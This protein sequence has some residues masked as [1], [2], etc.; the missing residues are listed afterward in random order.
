M[1][2][3]IGLLLLAIYLIIVGL[4]LVLGL[5]FQAK[6]IVE[7]ILAIIAGVLLILGR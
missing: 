2:K 3:N 1:Q 7:G 6:P 4:S 5:Q